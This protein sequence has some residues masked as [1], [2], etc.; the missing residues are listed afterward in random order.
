MFPPPPNPVA[1]TKHGCQ[2]SHLPTVPHTEDAEEK[3]RRVVLVT[4]EL[5]N[6]YSSHHDDPSGAT[7]SQDVAAEAANP[8]SQRQDPSEGMSTPPGQALRKWKGKGTYVSAVRGRLQRGEI[9][10]TSKSIQRKLVTDEE[11]RHSSRTVEGRTEMDL[12]QDEV[13]DCWRKPMWKSKQPRT[14]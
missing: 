8:S 5:S 12:V 2:K 9:T 1:S 6:V 11:K 7:D 14:K 13:D 3:G 10:G 4:L